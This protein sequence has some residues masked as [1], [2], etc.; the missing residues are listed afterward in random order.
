MMPLLF[1]VFSLFPPFC[2]PENPGAELCNREGVNYSD[3]LKARP[4]SSSLP[5]AR[6]NNHQQQLLCVSTR[7]ETGSTV[8]AVAVVVV[9]S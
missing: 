9:V 2:D 6:E 1:I 5:I 8:L 4:F 3:D 7:R